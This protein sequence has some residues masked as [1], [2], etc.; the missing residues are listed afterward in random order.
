VEGIRP[1]EFEVQSFPEGVAVWHH[2]FGLRAAATV[3]PA[4]LLL[5]GTAWESGQYKGPVSEVALEHEVTVPALGSSEI[6]WQISGGLTRDL[7]KALGDSGPAIASPD[8]LAARQAADDLQWTRGTPEL[9]F[10]DAPELEVAYRSARAGLR[11]L[12]S[13]PAEGMVGLVAGYPWY[14]AIWCRDLAIMLPALL[15]LGDFEWVARSLATVFGFQSR[16]SV[17]LLA[18]E[19]GEL[20]MQLVPG[21]IF[22]YGTSDSTLRFPRV[23]EQMH[24]HTGDLSS[25]VEWAEALHRIVEWGRGRS[26]PTTGLLRHGGEAEAISQATASLAR[27]RYGIDSPDTTIWDSADRRDHALDVQVLWWQA[28]CSTARLLGH[29]ADHDRRMTCEGQAAH[30]AE[31]LGGRYPWPEQRYLYDSLRGAIPVAR[32]RPNA[33]RAVS[34]GLLD[35]ATAR[36]VVERAAEGDLSTPWG[37]RSLSGNDPGYDAR[38]YHEGQ[39]WTIAT[40]WAADAAF[41]VGQPERGLAYLRTIAARYVADG[42]LANECYLGDRPEPFNSCYLLGFSV[43]PFLRLLFERLWGIRVDG[44]ET[45]VRVLPA[46][47]LAWTSAKLTGLRLA[48]GRLNLEWTPGHLRVQWEG[49]CGLSVDTGNAV[50]PIAPGETAVLDLPSPPERS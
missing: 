25:V 34:A 37:V 9:E 14:S 21:P 10:P 23:V 20:P 18:G 3:S 28:L 5:N 4:R 42:G 15:W 46:F 2:G 13:E 19:P 16:H 17:R 43:A 27:V 41:A 49:S 35:P 32:V 50:H 7:D 48:Q 38:A 22:L 30:L 40:A 8:D 31:T 12:Y 24:R 1:V 11:R 6:R 26:D 39:V 44:V 36:A 47:P 45:S 29:A 33:L